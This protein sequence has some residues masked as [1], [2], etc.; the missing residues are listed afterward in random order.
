MKTLALDVD[1]LVEMVDYY[2]LHHMP[3]LG[4]VT[5]V[6]HDGLNSRFKI[7]LEPRKSV[8]LASTP[9]PVEVSGLQAEMPRVLR[10]EGVR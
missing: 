4:K 9:V 1:E 2:V 6:S 7:S 5:S 10:Q 3:K 8:E